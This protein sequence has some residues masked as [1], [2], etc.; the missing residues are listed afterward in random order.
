MG[1]CLVVIE[2][3]YSQGNL[4]QINNSKDVVIKG[5]GFFQVMLLDGLLVYICDGFFQVDQNGQL[6]MVGGFQVQLV[7]IILV[8]VLSIIIGCDGVVSVI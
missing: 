6:V 7:I 3:L 8:N 5:Q 4:L 2:C 1:V